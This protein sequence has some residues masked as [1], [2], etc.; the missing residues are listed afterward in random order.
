MEFQSLEE[1]ERFDKLLA[2]YQQARGVPDFDW[3]S[4]ASAYE[5]L[6]SYSNGG[7]VFTSLL[8]LRFNVA[9]LQDELGR[10]ATIRNKHRQRRSSLK[11]GLLDNPEYLFERLDLLRANTAYILRY[12]AVLDKVMGVLVMLAAPSEYESFVNAKSRRKKFS[13]IGGSSKFLPDRLVSHVIQTVDVF[14]RYRTPEA[15]GTGGARKWSF[16]DDN[17]LE[18]PQSDM[19]WSWNSL[20][21]MLVAVGVLFGKQKDEVDDA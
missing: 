3:V 12:R 11:G 6:Q 5:L 14:N 18:S 13:E 15:H 9:T 8:D 16:I 17:D 2:E 20:R 10:M 21:P 1:V 4:L 7:K 19:F